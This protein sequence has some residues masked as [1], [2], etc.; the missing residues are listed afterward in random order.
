MLLIINAGAMKEAA[1]TVYYFTWHTD[2]IM[3]YVYYYTRQ[4]YI[5]Q[6]FE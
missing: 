4:A 3:Y 6:P 2:T 5:R 1:I